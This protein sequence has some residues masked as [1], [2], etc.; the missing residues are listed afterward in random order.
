MIEHGTE[1][2]YRYH[3]DKGE[4]PCDLCKTERNIR[5][6]KDY[7][8][9]KERYSKSAKIIYLKNKDNIKAKVK[10]WK[11]KNKDKIKSYKNRRRAKAKNS[12]WESYTVTQVLN[13]YGTKCFICKEEI[14]LSAP[15]YV[16]TEGWEM[17]LHLD[18][19]VSISKG[20]SDTIDNIRP[21]HGICNLR[22][23]TSE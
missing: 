20:G 9:N 1:T 15:R 22:K 5:R 23:G 8:D 10:I 17:G 12:G 7:K 4:K 14:D 21:T 11:S 3:Y 16:G 2:A 19:L 13:L 18:H 6:R